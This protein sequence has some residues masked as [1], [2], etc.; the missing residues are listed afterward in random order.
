MTLSVPGAAILHNRVLLVR[1]ENRTLVILPEN[2]TLTV[3]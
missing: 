1:G 3:H 2:R